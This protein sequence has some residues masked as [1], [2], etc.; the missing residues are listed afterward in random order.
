L[1]R[2]LSRKERDEVEAEADSMP[3]PGIGARIT[4]GVPM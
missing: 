1:W 2:R 3:L 4:F